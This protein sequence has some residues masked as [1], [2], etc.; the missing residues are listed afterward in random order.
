MNT[1]VD[2]IAVKGLKIRESD[3]GEYYWLNLTRHG[4]SYSQRFPK[5]YGQ[6]H[7]LETRE[8][9]QRWLE[10]DQGWAKDETE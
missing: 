1:I 2:E 9:I 7:I 5:D 8:A 4:V 6:H 10:A 3:N